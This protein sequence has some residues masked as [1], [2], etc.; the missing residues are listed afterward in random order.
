MRIEILGID[1]DARP[2][3]CVYSCNFPDPKD[4]N[5]DEILDRIMIKLDD[6]VENDYVIILFTAG[7]QSTRDT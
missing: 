1:Y 4:F 5:Y 7:T 3:L 2:I 6:F